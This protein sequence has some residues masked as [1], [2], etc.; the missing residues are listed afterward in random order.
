[1]RDAAAAPRLSPTATLR[2]FLFMAAMFALN[3]GAAV[4][5]LSFAVAELGPAVG[6]AGAFT[7]RSWRRRYFVVRSG[8]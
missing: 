3:H 7:S 5:C 6:N 4:G 2:S 1:M 8:A